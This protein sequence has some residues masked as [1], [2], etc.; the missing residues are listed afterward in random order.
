MRDINPN[1]RQSQ[2]QGKMIL[3]AM[4]NGERLTQLEAYVRFGCTRLGAR[5]Y[6]L[7][8]QGYRIERKMITVPNV[9]RVMQYWIDVEVVE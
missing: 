2:S 5:I 4:L 7:T 3:S 8:N 1:E 6:D 9:K